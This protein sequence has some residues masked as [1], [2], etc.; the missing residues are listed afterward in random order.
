MES[1]A[2]AIYLFAVILIVFS[3][4]V[5][6]ANSVINPTNMSEIKVSTS[7]EITEQITT[8]ELVIE[9]GDLKNEE[10]TNEFFLVN[11]ELTIEELEEDSTIQKPN[12]QTPLI[13]L[14]AL[15]SYLLHKN[16]CVKLKDLPENFEI[17]QDLK[18]YNLRGDKV[19]RVSALEALLA[20]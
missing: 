16:R 18:T 6:P 15:K 9:E 13:D 3:W 10:L 14:K 17:P 8:E 5:A 7:E 19:I 4:L 12:E 1:I 11:P 2:L 20:I